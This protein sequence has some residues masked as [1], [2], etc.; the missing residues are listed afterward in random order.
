LKPSGGA[1]EL[2]SLPTPPEVQIT[3]TAPPPSIAIASPANDAAYTQGQAVAAIYSCTASVGT[4]I[5]ACAGS[6]ANGAALDTAALG[7]HVFTV[8]AEDTDGGKT[9]KSVH[10]TVVAAPSPK[11][12][13]TILGSHPKKTI[14]TKKKKVKVKFTFSSTVAGS[15][16]KCKLDKGAFAPCTSPK[17]YK[18]KLGRHKFSVEAVNA[19]V[20]DPIAAAF[21]F[22]VKKKS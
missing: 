10:Y 13:D 22:R 1:L 11:A 6:V 2:A 12:A 19:G 20:V 15:S 5:T 16:F 14:K 4:G 9:D 7:E 21:E 18:V 17:S 8:H 3:Y